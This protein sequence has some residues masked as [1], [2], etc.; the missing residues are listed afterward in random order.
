M[1]LS[2]RYVVPPFLWKWNGIELESKRVQEI[3]SAIDTTI[4][5]VLEKY[6]TEN[7]SEID[8]KH[9]NVMQ[10]L[11]Q[12]S[13]DGE[14]MSNDEIVGEMKGFF[15]AGHETSSN[16]LT[17]TM[18]ELARNPN[19]LEKLRLEVTRVDLTSDINWTEILPQLKY[20]AAYSRYLENVV[21]ESMRLHSVV[22]AT[23]RENEH[24]EEILGYKFAPKTKFRIMIAELHKNEKYWE[25]PDVFNPDR[26]TKEVVPGS[27]MPFLD[28]PHN[29]IGY[30]LALIEIKVL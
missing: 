10:R 25:F 15:I 21:K 23:M 19:V 3:R 7:L 28:G 12:K 27:Y 16:A 24:E 26:F 2:K 20:Y 5:P 18:L 1:N 6:R 11:C 9:W 22:Q 8:G 4:I 13:I 30:K 17:W 29:C 14:T